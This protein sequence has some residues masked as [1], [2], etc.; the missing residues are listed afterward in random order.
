MG[1]LLQQGLGAKQPSEPAKSRLR[2]TEGWAWSP[3]GLNMSSP[4]ARYPLS[5][6]E[7]VGV[8]RLLRCLYGSSHCQVAVWQRPWPH[9]LTE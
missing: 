7:S 6:A 3:K 8:S 1:G 9:M 2:D 4:V 5:D